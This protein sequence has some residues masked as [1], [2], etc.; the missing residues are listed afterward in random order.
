MKSQEISKIISKLPDTPGVYLFKRGKETLYVGKATS[1]RDR[2]RSYFRDDIFATRGPLI[3]KMLSEF[4]KIEHIQTDSVLEALILE[5]EIIKKLQPPANTAEKDDKSWNYVAI[6][7]EK[8]PRILLVR[9]HDLK[10]KSLDFKIKDKFGPFTNG[11]QLKEALRI[12]RKIFPY[13]D[14]KCVPKED[15][16]NQ[17]GKACFNKQIGLCPGVCTGEISATDYKKQIRNIILFFEGRKKQLTKNLERDMKTAAKLR[18]FELAEKT[19]RQIFALNHIRDVS[20]IKETKNAPVY[21]KNSSDSSSN[22]LQNK[23]VFRI[24]AYDIAHTAGS[25][26]VGVMTVVE[27]DEIK[28]ADYRKF[29]IKTARN[30]DIAALCE[31]LDRRLTHIEWPMP[32]IIVVD[33]GNAQKNAAEKILSKN[34]LDITVVSVVKDEHH[35][36]KQILGETKLRLDHESAILRANAEA[37]RFAIKYHR[38]KRNDFPHF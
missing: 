34:N 14:S 28:P 11:G 29:Q 1:L 19:K 15:Q 32:Q 27:N 12:V 31:I 9:A 2:V 20:L 16:K 33:G 30:N 38:Q 13:R 24:E 3:V 23:N 17:A 36:P 8:F 35:K 5:A 26:T 6:T 4:D 7:E 18:Q 37:H 21:L 10:Y 22:N 25:N